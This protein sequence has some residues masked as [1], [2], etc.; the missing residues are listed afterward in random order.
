MPP[1]LSPKEFFPGH[2]PCFPIPLPGRVILLDCIK[3]AL[4]SCVHALLEASLPNT[5]WFRLHILLKNL[6][7][8]TANLFFYSKY[9][10]LRE[11]SWHGAERVFLHRIAAFHHLRGRLLI[12]GQTVRPRLVITPA[13]LHVT[14]ATTLSI[15][16]PHLKLTCKPIVM[17]D[18]PIKIMEIIKI[19]LTIKITRFQS[20]D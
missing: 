17:T 8:A 5:W 12:T 7:K 1:S 4:S 10:G 11:W 19:M 14:H 13:M 2:L 20:E 15:Y 9:P 3:D 16:L 18:G 6:C